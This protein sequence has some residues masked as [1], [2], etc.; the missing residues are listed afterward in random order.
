MRVINEDEADFVADGFYGRYYIW[1]EVGVKTIGDPYKT[2]WDLKKSFEWKE[3]KRE[4]RILEDLKYSGITPKP[5]GLAL[6]RD[7]YDWLKVAIMMEHIEWDTLHDIFPNLY[8]ID[9]DDL[10]LDERVPKFCGLNIFVYAQNKLREFG[11]I[12][13]DLH[14]GNVLAKHKKYVIT[15][16]RV[17]DFTPE[18]MEKVNDLD[19]VQ[20]LREH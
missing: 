16:V 20:K 6:F 5:Y 13:N 4:L 14:E 8:D 11:Y 19:K 3:A 15:D 7:D 9:F 18:L 17:I 2:A 10:T 12:H 1:E